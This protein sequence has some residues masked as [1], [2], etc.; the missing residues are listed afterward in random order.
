MSKVL[1][2][3]HHLSLSH[4]PFPI[5]MAGFAVHL[6]LLM[7]YPTVVIGRDRSSKLSKP[8][9]LESNLLEQLVKKEALECRGPSDEVSQSLSGQLVV[10]KEP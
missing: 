8:G 4:R 6:C 9:Y 7:N 10:F 3:C 5:D 2:I 1:A